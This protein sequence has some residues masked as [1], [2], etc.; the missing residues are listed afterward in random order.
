MTS[1]AWHALDAAEV[2]A[3]LAADPGAGLS[4]DKARARLK[5]VGPNR[6]GEHRERPIWRLVLDQ[7]GS[8]VVLLLLGAAVVAWG[9]GEGL[10]AVAILA[11]LLLNAA[12]GAGS[13]WRARRSLA[14]LRALAVPQALVR[15]GGQTLSIPSVDLVPGDLIVLEAGAQVPADARLVSTAALRVNE[16]SLT[17]ESLPADKDAQARLPADTPLSERC[18]MVYLGTGVLA[19]TGTAVVT[20]T[21]LVTE[22]GKIGQL[23]ALAGERETPLEA[24]V[25]TLGR[26][27]V[28]L[29][30]AI[31]AVVGVAGILHGEPIALMLETAISLAVAAIPESLPAITTV[32]LA[33]GL[34]R[35]A[36]AGALVRRLPAVET[37]GSTTVICADKTGTMTENQMTVT[38]LVLV[39]RSLA[40]SGGGRSAA[41]AITEDGARVDALD[42]PLVR[43]LLTAGVLVNDA[44]AA[45]GEDELALGGDPTEAAL[46]VAA[47]KAASILRRSGWPGRAGARSHSIRARG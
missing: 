46:L 25:E 40:V 23:V 15:R 7:F 12:V 27:L 24:Q 19:G 13:E 29:A 9:M 30:L 22:L 4:K 18:T 37:L 45:P 3:L 34:W 14:R 28:V 47:S 44:H 32:A 11:A 10:E 17:G 42:D 41:G 16:A 26:R 43:L 31:C 1:Q 21:G 8:L 6:V 33:A 38:R 36:R 20:E 5:R 39:G 2:A 35:L